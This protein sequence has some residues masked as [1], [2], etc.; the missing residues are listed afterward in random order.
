M[1]TVVCEICALILLSFV[2]MLPLTSS[3]LTCD[4]C[5]KK[6]DLRLYFFLYSVMEIQIVAYCHQKR[7]CI[8][9]SF[10]I[11]NFCV[12]QLLLIKSAVS[13]TASSKK[14]RSSKQI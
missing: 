13:V 7:Q 12:F 14:H 1:I 4:I 2:I 11:E 8:C 10:I 3:L 6:A 9:N 5:N